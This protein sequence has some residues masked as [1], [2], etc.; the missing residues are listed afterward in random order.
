MNPALQPPATADWNYGQVVV[1]IGAWVDSWP[2]TPASP[3]NVGA[4]IAVGHFDVWMGMW[5]A[6]NLPACN[7]KQDND[8]DGTKDYPKENVPAAVLECWGPNDNS[9]LLDCND[10]RDN[11][12]DGLTDSGLGGDDGCDNATDPSEKEQ[13]DDKID[14]DGDGLTD[15]ADQTGGAPPTGPG[16]I[17]PADNNEA[18]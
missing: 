14:N 4:G 17:G 6:C 12:G 18:A 10:G 5:G 1:F 8:G 3:T 15:A 2:G 11:D 13:C 9:E 7:D 16:C